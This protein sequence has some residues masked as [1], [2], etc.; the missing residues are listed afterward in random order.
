MRCP[1]PQPSIF[2]KTRSNALFFHSVGLYGQTYP[3]KSQHKRALRFLSV[4]IFFK[5][6]ET[7]VQLHTFNSK[8]IIT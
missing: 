8:E 1:T 5:W 2:S 3:E 6:T 4:F 7:D